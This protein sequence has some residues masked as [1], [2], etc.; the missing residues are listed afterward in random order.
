M[1]PEAMR[2]QGAGHGV[3]SPPGKGHHPVRDPESH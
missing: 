1:T 3:P 2:E